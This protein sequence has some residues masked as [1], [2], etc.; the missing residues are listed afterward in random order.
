MSLFSRPIDQVGRV[1]QVVVILNPA[2]GRG[3]GQKRRSELERLLAHVAAG[4]P[5]RAHWEIVTTQVPC[6]GAWLAAEAV[7]RGADVVAA[8]GGDGTC[9]EVVNGLVG[10]GARLGILPLGTGNDF[11]RTLG[12]AGRLEK[13]V[14]A[15]FYGTPKPVD[16]GRTGKRWFINVA[17]CGFDAAV[18]ER[19]HRGFRYVKGTSAYIVAVLHALITFRPAYMRITADGVTRELRAMLCC[20]ANA[21]SYGGGMKIAPD[22]R[23][24][25][26]LFDLCIVREISQWE[27]LRA[28]P[29]VFKGTHITH[30]KVTILRARHVRLESDTALPVFID[31]EVFGTTPCEFEIVPRAIEVMTP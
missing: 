10:T 1:R 24:D 13:A 5:Q 2:A 20:L 4:L 12:L 17:G 23:I 16:L 31:G 28:F 18:A 19:V 9:N 27:F 15:L 22:A 30:P 29:R 8:A 7:A 3:Q 6:S 21:Q 26:G 11:A 14:H 25:D